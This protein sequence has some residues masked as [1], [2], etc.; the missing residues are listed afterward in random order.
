MASVLI[1]YSPNVEIW[2]SKYDS[3]KSQWQDKKKCFES[4]LEN[5]VK[6]NVNSLFVWIGKL[7]RSSEEERGVCFKFMIIAKSNNVEK[8]RKFDYIFKSIIII[9]LSLVP[10]IGSVQPIGLIRKQKHVELWIL[11][12]EREREERTQIPFV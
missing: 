3:I 7:E 6:I 8:A 2:I 12:A 11:D 5:K 9:F 1:S 4:L 10:W